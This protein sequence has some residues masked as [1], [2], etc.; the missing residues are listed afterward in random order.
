METPA[1]IPF[2]C[3][4]PC[5]VWV[6]PALSIFRRRNASIGVSPGRMSAVCRTGTIF[7]DTWGSAGVGSLVFAAGVGIRHGTSALALA[8]SIAARADSVSVI[9]AFLRL[10]GLRPNSRLSHCRS[11]SWPMSI[12][13]SRRAPISVPTDSPAW[14]RRSNSSR[15]DASLIVARLRGQRTRATASANVGGEVGVVEECA[16]SDMGVTGE[17][18][19]WRL[20]RARGVPRAHSKRQRLDVGVLTY[21]FVFILYDAVSS[22]FGFMVGRFVGLIDSLVVVFGVLVEWIDLDFRFLRF[23]SF[24]GRS[25][26]GFF[27]VGLMVGGAGC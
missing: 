16:G 13:S 21:A 18:Y 9:R 3:C 2:A 10:T 14:R 25:V 20:S 19:A 11:V 1:T 12:P 26:L 6:A 27:G 17:R 24:L 22:I 15:C 8:G 5:A 23:A 7:S 4:V